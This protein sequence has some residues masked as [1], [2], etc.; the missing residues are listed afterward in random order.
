LNVSIDFNQ[1]GISKGT[2]GVDIH[3]GEKYPFANGSQCFKL[4]AREARM[5]M[6]SKK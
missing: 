3:S 4:G 5:I 1:A 6:F 2:V